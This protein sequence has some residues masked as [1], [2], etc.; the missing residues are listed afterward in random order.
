LEN[1]QP[2]NLALVH[3]WPSGLERLNGMHPVVDQQGPFVQ[4]ML[5]RN[6][7]M[8]P[9]QL[10]K[11]FGSLAAVSMLIAGGLWILGAPL[12]LLF[13][14]LEI[15]ALG[16]AF[17]VFAR[18]AQ[19]GERVWLDQAGLCVEVVR[20]Q[21][22]KIRRF[23]PHWV[24]IE[25]DRAARHRVRIG[26]HDELIEIG[27]FVTEV[28]RRQVVAEIRGQLASYAGAAPAQ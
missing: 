6:C 23:D 16:A 24:R 28:R 13:S 4:W 15:V 3:D 17:V 1:P 18:H 12:V 8:A 14:G 26:Q 19:D 2:Y 7:S 5:K 9:A 20:A 21:D 11:V 25:V 10:A 22:V 27:Q